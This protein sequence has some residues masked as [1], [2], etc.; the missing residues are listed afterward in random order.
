MIL[1]EGLQY[2]KEIQACCM[3]VNLTYLIHY[4]LSMRYQ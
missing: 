3:T 1:A 2:T 4:V